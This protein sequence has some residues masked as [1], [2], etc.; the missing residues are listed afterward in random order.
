MNKINIK[1]V[2]R[3]VQSFFVKRSPA[4]LA[5]IGI[6]GM[7]S[8]TVMAVKAT[9]L[10]LE[11]INDKKKELNTYELTP[12]ETVM[13]T[14]K[15]YAPAAITCAVS[16]ACIIG[17]NKV[18]AKR[19][20]ALATAYALSE[21]TIKEYKDKV[22]ETIGEKKEKEVRSAISKDRIEQNPVSTSEVI[23]TGKGDS[24]FYEPLSGRYFRCDIERIKKVVNELNRQMIYDSYISLNELYD[25]IGS[26]ELE[27][28]DIG[29]ELGW[30]ID[31]S[32]I[33]IDYDAFVADSGEPCIT[34]Y[35]VNPPMYN[36]NK[37]L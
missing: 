18:S 15:C 36:Y 29:S 35:Y 1:K 17:S 14:W 4:I 22:I 8:S 13:T 6:A 20:A 37:F 5:G 7:V 16:V 32:F 27:R 31:N 3:G 2:G 10:A 24:L 28:N 25:A 23:I 12:V 9:P 34:M 33:E 19:N 26:K 21:T 30:N 11:L